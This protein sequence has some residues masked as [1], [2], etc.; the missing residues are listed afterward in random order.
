MIEPSWNNITKKNM[1]SYGREPL[2]QTRIRLVDIC[3]SEFLKYRP[4]EFR[5]GTPV[6]AVIND[7]D[8]HPVVRRSEEK[9]P[10]DTTK[11]PAKVVN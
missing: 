4:H 5:I 6:H 8:L 2:P 1:S 7:L 10:L 3:I 9:S 11:I